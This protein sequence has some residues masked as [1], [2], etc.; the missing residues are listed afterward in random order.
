[1]KT[2]LDTSL[3]VRLQEVR[4]LISQNVPIAARRLREIAR[5][6]LR[7]EHVL[8]IA[9]VI[10][11]LVGLEH[12]M[13][14]RRVYVIGEPT[15]NAVAAAIAV[16]ALAEE[17]LVEVQIA[18]YGAVRQEVLDPSSGL[19]SFNPNFVLIV[20]NPVLQP[21]VGDAESA[22][23][24]VED[25][26]ESWGKLW[27]TISDRLPEVRILHHLYEQP[28]LT[29]SGIAERRLPWSM[30]T[31]T[32][33]VNQ[34]LI[35]RA[36]NLVHLIDMDRL[37]A[38]IGRSTWRDQRLWF[39]GRLPFAPRH[40]MS[41]LDT[42][43]SAFRRASGKVKKA[44]ILD[45]D[46]TLWGGVIGDDGLDGIKLGPGDPVSEAY[47]EFASYVQQL[48]RRGVILGVCSKNDY[49]TA[50]RVFTDHPHMPLKLADFAVFVCNWDDKAS[51]LRYMIATLNID[52][53]TVVFADDNRFECG[54][55]QQEISA[56]EVIELTGDAA[57]FASK[58]DRR[59]LFETDRLSS[60]DFG[61]VASY[62]ALEAAA[63]LKTTTGNL[64]DYL[65]GLKM[66]GQFWPARPADV[67]RLAQME[68]KTNQFNITSR[69]FSSEQILH[70]IE[71]PTYGIYCFKLADRFADHGLVGSMVVE[72]VNDEARIISWLLSCRVFSRTCEEFMLD[73]LVRRVFK[74]P[75]IERLIGIYVSSEKN[76]VVAGLFQRLGFSESGQGN[77]VMHLRQS[78]TIAETFIADSDAEVV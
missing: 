52:P 64:T 55:V 68:G 76:K 51:N 26:A 75:A 15:I 12:G 9:E 45:L 6:E 14:V 10:S 70:F 43:A 47:A 16:A 30:W 3:A 73:Q 23:T 17:I 1:M 42:I 74:E 49:A 19:Y 53:A 7:S 4:V 2:E 60:E 71:S 34:A 66:T 38:E 18:S 44:L 13:A 21:N 11:R 28:D 36:P 37:A 57:G 59:R 22:A 65:R 25:Q 41:Y 63:S 32:Q 50:S 78:L 35:D 48:G 39:H 61:R 8:P 58:I 29:P 56:V 24:F 33:S 62:R 54:L 27:T 67:V 46:N 20:P 31:I 77:Y 5:G 40:L 72:Y 69:R